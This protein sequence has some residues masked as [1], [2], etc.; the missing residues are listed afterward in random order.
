MKVLGKRPDG[1][2]DIYSWFQALDLAD[3]MEIEN[4]DGGGID[5]TSDSDTIP[6]GGENL[7]FQ[8][9]RRM[10][11]LYA[12]E[13][14]FRIRLWKHIPVA[15]GLGGGSSDA[16]ACIKSINK[17]LQL[18]LSVEK[19]RKIGLE[20]GSDVPFFFSRGQAE[21]T[22]RGENVRE[23]ELPTDY[24]VFLVTP[25]LQIRAAE[26]YSRVKIGLT[27]PFSGVSL[28][29][30]QPAKE[31]FRVI[32]GV[33][34]DL[35][36]PLGISYPVLARIKKGLTGTG[37]DIVRLSGSGPTVFAL[38]GGHSGFTEKKIMAAFEGEGWGSCFASPVILPA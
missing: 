16:A 29:C 18:R 19:M 10:K 7:I 20:I 37:A 33:G 25:P 27:K 34:N 3:H 30:C 13:S 2:H 15:A 17:L 14:G 8:A 22:G 32:S 24:R 36:G 35:E 1:Y 21:V 6:T 9:A 31:L 11:E 26:A 23:I 28:N 38:Y 5:L 12:P 4:T